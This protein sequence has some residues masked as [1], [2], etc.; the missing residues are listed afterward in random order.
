VSPEHAFGLK[1]AQAWDRPTVDALCALLHERASLYQP[2]RPPIR[3]RDAA[4]G[5]FARLLRWLPGLRGDV[6]LVRG[7]DGAVFIE[8][9]MEFPIGRGVSLRAVDRILLRDG[10]VLE[11][12][13]YFDPRALMLAVLRAPAQWRGY[14][15]YRFGRD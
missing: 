3:G 4:R 7:G 5:E 6:E 2:H 8:W 12:R 9:Q 15:R 11:R 13:V 14:L 1:F 10:L